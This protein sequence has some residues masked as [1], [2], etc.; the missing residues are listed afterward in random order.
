MV[1]N[2]RNSQNLSTPRRNILN[3]PPGVNNKMENGEFKEQYPFRIV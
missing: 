2:L 3:F 1:E